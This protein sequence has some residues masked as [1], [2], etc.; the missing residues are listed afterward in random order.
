[1]NK[2]L[3]ANKCNEF[4]GFPATRGCKKKTRRSGC[5]LTA[6]KRQIT[7]H[8]QLNHTKNASMSVVCFLVSLA[9]FGLTFSVNADVLT[10]NNGNEIFGNALSISSGVIEFEAV[11]GKQIYQ[12]TQAMKLEFE[13]YKTVP[14]ETTPASIKDPIIKKLLEK[15]PTSDEFPQA[16]KIDVLD[17]D[18]FDIASDGSFKHTTHDIFVVIKEKAREYANHSFT[19]FPDIENYEVLYGRSIT[20]PKGGFLG[21]IGGTPGSVRYI[22]D[23]TVAD[24]TD[25]SRYPLYQKRH[26]VK[27]AIPEVNPGT[28]VDRKYSVIRNKCDPLRPFFAEKLFRGF[29]PR[30]VSRLIIRVPCEKKLLYKIEEN[31]VSLSVNIHESN[32]KMVHIFEA[33]GT[34]AILQEPEMPSVERIAPRV[35]CTLEDRWEDIAARFEKVISPIREKAMKDPSVKQALETACNNKTTNDEKTLAI[36]QFVGKEISLVGIAAKAYSFE[37]TDPEKILKLKQGNWTDKVFLYHVL[38]TMA[39]IQNRLVLFR[40]KNEGEWVSGAPNLM[41]SSFMTVELKNMPAL[42][43]MNIPQSETSSPDIRP[44]FMQGARGFTIPEGEMIDIPLTVPEKEGEKSVCE[45]WIKEDGSLKMK[46]NMFPMGQGET[47]LRALKYLR[48]DEKK[49]ALENYLHNDYPGAKLLNYDL[50]NL[51]DMRKPVS[52]AME[53]E[54]ADFVVKSGSDLVAIPLPLGKAEYSAAKVGS[55]QRISDFNWPTLWHDEKNIIIHL[56]K[57]FTLYALPEGSYGFTD[58]LFYHSSFGYEIGKITFRDV[59]IRDSDILSV[60]DYPSYKKFIED[61]SQTMNQ[62]IIIAKPNGN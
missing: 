38:L 3:S 20:P 29:E 51:D 55:P 22:S 8:S 46:M 35:V 30:L 47:S 24:E 43:S 1:M 33:S 48:G 34:T 40:T 26:T 54:V 27:F 56:P 28:I 53:F 44:S 58:G 7:I 14:G 41:Q 15:T 17:E 49:K 31:G 57:G 2:A 23:Q 13:T 59:F 11:G 61:R 21:I 32:G 25:F 42:L 39:G 62:W 5:F 36:F 60:S 4:L 52:L 6:S 12:A 18:E 19:Y 10:F 37:P 16:S 50:P 45:A 9:M